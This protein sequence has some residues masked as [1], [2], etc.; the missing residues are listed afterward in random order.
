VY[1][2]YP[3]E[4]PASGSAVTSEQ[5]V[6]MFLYAQDATAAHVKYDVKFKGFA[7]IKYLHRDRQTGAILDS[8]DFEACKASEFT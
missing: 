1:S 4:V 7:T 3:F 8:G 6:G 5:P 2:E